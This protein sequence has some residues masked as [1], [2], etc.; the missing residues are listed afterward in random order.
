MRNRLV[1]TLLTVVSITIIIFLLIYINES[2]INKRE[3]A[4]L[5]RVEKTS[6]HND[7]LIGYAESESLSGTE[8]YDLQVP[9]YNQMEA[10]S[11][12][13]GCEVTALSM[14][15]SH[16][17]F[18]YDKN[19]LQDMIYK[20]V[21]QDENGF[22]G[23]PDIGFVGDATGETPGT[24]VNV[25]PIVQLANDIVGDNYQVV[26]SS[27]VSIDELLQSVS[28]G[29]PIWI[30]VSIDYTIPKKSDF[31]EWKTKNGIKKISIKHHAAVITGFDGETVFLN[32]S[33]GKKVTI[34]KKKL[35][36]IYIGMGS[37]SMFLKSKV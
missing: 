30:A 5:A 27:G 3:V 14:I 24:G 11:L 17:K 21:Y 23:D 32:D 12:K 10:P 34:G 15:L 18:N 36:D 13:Y 26:N 33:Y 29:S 22:L 19:T 37:Q 8:F 20:E 9:L 2:Y 31:I 28:E 16:Y 7:L 35:D 4:R 6:F 1:K 25:G